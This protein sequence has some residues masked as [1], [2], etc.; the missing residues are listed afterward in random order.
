MLF[1]LSGPS[2]TKVRLCSLSLCLP[3]QGQTRQL[4]NLRLLESS[5]IMHFKCLKKQFLLIIRWLAHVSFP[6]YLHSKCEVQSV[7]NSQAFEAARGSQFYRICFVVGHL[8]YQSTSACPPPRIFGKLASC[9][10]RDHIRAMLGHS[11]FLDS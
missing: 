11:I 10:I 9:I 6:L 7:I 4:Q 5:R 8:K 2:D 3:I 1:L